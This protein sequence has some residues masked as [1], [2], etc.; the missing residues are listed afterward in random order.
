M[1]R[2]SFLVVVFWGLVLTSGEVFS[3]ATNSSPW[4][5][6]APVGIDTK[7]GL[8]DGAL[9][10]LHINKDSSSS[11][12]M[13]AIIRLSNGGLSPS[14][15]YGIL[16][17]MSPSTDTLYSSLSKGQDLVLHENK[18]GDIIITNYWA[19]GAFSSQTG[20]AIR[21]ATAGDTIIQPSPKQSHHDLER[22]TI[23]DNGNVGI[24]LPPDSI[25]LDTPK[26]QLQFGG[27]SLPA[28][29]ELDPTPGLTFYGG[30]RYEGLYNTGG[31]Y[32]AD[33]RYINFNSAI[34]HTDSSS[35]RFFRLARMGSCGISFTNRVDSE[36]G[37]VE[38]NAWPYSAGRGQNNF[39]Q[40][41]TLQVDGHYGLEMWYLDTT[42]NP[43]HHL[44]DV[45]Q[46]GALPYGVTRNI[47]GISYFH[48]PLCIGVDTPGKPLP[49]FT[50]FSNVRPD[51]GDGLTWMLAVSGAAI[52]K[53]FYI[54][55][56]SWADYV[57]EPGYQLKPLAEVENFTKE[58]HHLPDI[59]SAKQM[60]K[61]GVPV[62]RTEEAITKQLEEEMLY[63]E[64][65]NHKIE[66]LEAEVQEL[67][68]QKEK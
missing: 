50:N 11:S 2:W 68:N 48:T 54:L 61:T 49:D 6:H 45:F 8:T 10:A 15:Y 19:G 66:S 59:P 55:D 4:P 40:C 22:L 29:G 43:Y 37:V 46:P 24:N 47:S 5:A 16:G 38:L 35:A 27:G 60:A 58:N 20:G 32:P 17:L 62:G 36:S 56:S 52:A 65:L 67:K 28:A 7:Y 41:V 18:G 63:I 39:S 30:N 51:I 31:K 64:Q 3:Q 21:F 33:W 13:E 26:D 1:R 53:E 9:N 34:N 23:L 42:S 12:T 25:G 14:N 44:F 57:F